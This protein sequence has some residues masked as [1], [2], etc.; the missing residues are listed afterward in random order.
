M[1]TM[2][3]TTKSLLQVILLRSRP[4]N[5]CYSRKGFL[6]FHERGTKKKNL[7]IE[8]QTFHR[9][10]IEFCWSLIIFQIYFNHYFR[11]CY[12]CSNVSSISNLKPQLIEIIL[13]YCYLCNWK[14]VEL[15]CC[16]TRRLLNASA[17]FR[18]SMLTESFLF[19]FGHNIIV[20]T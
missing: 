10:G 15:L 4:L 16:K 12:C 3:G 17:P 11:I 2:N 18:F 14:R 1:G 6:S 9:Q 19:S 8:P 20:T 5:D 7:L 13:M